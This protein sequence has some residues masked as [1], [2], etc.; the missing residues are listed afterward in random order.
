MLD[1]NEV[2]D[3]DHGYD[4]EVGQM[5]C[6]DL[7]KCGARRRLEEQPEELAQARSDVLDGVAGRRAEER[8]PDGDFNDIDTSEITDMSELFY[9]MQKFNGNI[10]NWNVSNV[11]TMCSMFRGCESFNQDISKWGVSKVEYNNDVFEDC[12]IKETYKPKFK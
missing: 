3:R 12:P 6:G 4:G 1:E 2:V 8:G 7:R 5:H 10:S 9:Y 11:V